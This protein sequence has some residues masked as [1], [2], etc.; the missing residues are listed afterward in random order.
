MKSCSACHGTYPSH[1]AVCPRDGTPLR[2]VGAWT[3]GFLVRGKY[4]IL[5]KLGQGG[6]GTVYKAVHVAFDE[7]RALKVMS[8]DLLSDQLFVKRFVQEAVITRKLQHPNAVR[9]EDIDEAEDGCPFIVMEFIEG[10][11]LRSLIQEQG[12]IPVPRVCSIAKQVAAALDAAHGLGMVHRDIKPDNIVLLQTP[13][14]EQAKVLDFGIAK[15]KESRLGS[16]GGL[17]LTGTG[18]VIGTPQYIS[19]EQA[20]GKRGD[21]LDGRS[22]L[23]SLGVV[24][25]QMLAGE[26]PFKAD[27]TMEMLL[28]H[29]QKPPKPLKD[30]RPELQIP[31]SITQIVMNLLEKDPAARPSSARVLIEQIERAEQEASPLSETREVRPIDVIPERVAPP[32]PELSK[33]LV[34]PEV[35][36]TALSP[37]LLRPH[38]ARREPSPGF[39]APRPGRP[40][41]SAEPTAPISMPP[42]PMPPA[43]S[44]KLPLPPKTEDPQLKG[45]QSPPAIPRRWTPSSDVRAPSRFTGTRLLVPLVAVVALSGLFGYFRFIAPTG[46]TEMESPASP[47]VPAQKG[48]EN[49]LMRPSPEIGDRGAR[50]G[51]KTQETGSRAEPAGANLPT[52]SHS[53]EVHQD[54]APSGTHPAALARDQQATAKALRLGND[55]FENGR[56]DEAIAEY[57]KGLQA[58]PGNARLLQR[59]RTVHRVKEAEARILQQR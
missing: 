7:M 6:M 11:S 10:Q 30:L 45:T 52:R 49:P 37:E 1:F 12:S 16:S 31:D 9:V 32:R 26:L 14:G 46:P 5:S 53:R 40:D 19:P 21:Q 35:E 24:M 50:P 8:P 2:E 36:P 41:I 43:P 28:A 57:Q 44:S 56:Y 47:R 13:H 29:L 48:A 27:T 18:V 55:H 17:T 25:Y 20:M 58:D 42:A 51:G 54:S 4:R 39:S 22:D 34:P 38:N 23:Y 3:E 59:I 15:I 33:P